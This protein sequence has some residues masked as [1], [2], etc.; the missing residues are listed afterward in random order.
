MGFCHYFIGVYFLK[1]TVSDGLGCSH[2]LVDGMSFQ[3]QDGMGQIIHS[4]L[5]MEGDGHHSSAT[6]RGMMC[7]PFR[8]AF[9]K[10]RTASDKTRMSIE[11]G[12]GQVQRNHIHGQ[13]PVS[14]RPCRCVP[15]PHLQSASVT[16]PHLSPWPWALCCSS[17]R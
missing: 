6:I 11:G 7:I 1:G 14:H 16:R 2:T 4:K 9:A 8:M 5:R 17:H 3:V 13:C 10:P 15:R 12:E